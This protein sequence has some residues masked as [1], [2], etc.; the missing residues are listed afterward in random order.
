MMPTEKEQLRLALRSSSGALQQEDRDQW[1]RMAETLRSVMEYKMT[2]Q[3]FVG[4]ADALRQARINVLVDGKDLVMPGAGLKEGFFLLR[5][6]SVPYKDLGTA[7][8]YRGLARFGQRLPFPDMAGINLGMILTDALAIDEQGQRLG[9]G[10]G[11][12]DLTYALLW[13]AGAANAKTMVL[14]LVPD[15]R[16]VKRTLPTD[17]WDVGMHGVVTPGGGRIFADVPQQSAR[18]FWERLSQDRIRRMAPLWRLYSHQEVN[19][20]FP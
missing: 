19:S 18:I 10:Q 3:L 1:G 8:T 17:P 15:H 5:A 7:V 13:Q 2:R 12:F 16:L 4:P 20:C 6:H 11:Y 9:D 14:A